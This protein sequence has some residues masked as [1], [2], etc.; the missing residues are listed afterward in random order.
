[1]R[2]RRRGPCTPTMFPTTKRPGTWWRLGRHSLMSGKYLSG[3]GRVRMIPARSSGYF[4]RV[5]GYKDVASSLVGAIIVA[6]RGQANPDGT[7]KDVDRE[8]VAL[9]T[10]FNEN[11][12][13]YV[14][15]NACRTSLR[16][17]CLGFLDEPHR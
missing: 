17:S 3:R 8:I 12:S 9:F 15:E 7:P 6:R 11:Q 16:R 5:N 1:M 4:T 10:A 2:R 14:R 13:W